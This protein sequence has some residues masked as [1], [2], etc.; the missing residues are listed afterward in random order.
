MPVSADCPSRHFA[1]RIKSVAIGSE[2]DIDGEASTTDSDDRLYGACQHPGLF[3]R[4]VHY[5][6]LRGARQAFRSHAKRQAGDRARRAARGRWAQAAIQGS[7]RAQEGWRRHPSAR[8]HYHSEPGGLFQ[9]RSST[10]QRCLGLPGTSTSSS[11]RRR[12]SAFLGFDY[13]N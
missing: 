11:P 13:D 7:R 1:A 5:R 10:S 8:N 9:P 4:R 12:R 2:A 3:A 6:R